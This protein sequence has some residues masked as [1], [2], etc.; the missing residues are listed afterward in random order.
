MA[1]L[2]YGMHTIALVSKVCTVVSGS[3]FSGE[4]MRFYAFEVCCSDFNISIISITR[5]GDYMGIRTVS[6]HHCCDL[7]RLLVD[8]QAD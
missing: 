2:S 6:L 7:P 8:R 5:I 4:T 3:Y 1:E